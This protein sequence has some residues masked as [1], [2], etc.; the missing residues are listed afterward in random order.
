MAPRAVIYGCRGLALDAA[1]RAFFREAAPWGF[2]LFGRNVGSPDQVRRLVAELRA[3]VGREAPVLIDQEGGRV[4]RLGPPDWRGWSEAR[5]ECAAV[6]PALRPRAMALR[7][8]L[9]G[10]ELR[11]LGIDVN[12]APVLD[13]SQ[14]DTHPFLRSRLYGE[15]AG[16]VAA[17]GRAVADGLLAEGVLPI[18]KHIPGHGRARADSHE[19]LPVVEADLDALDRVDFAPFRDL[20]DLPMAMTAHVVYPALDAARPATLSPVVVKAIRER[21]GF[22]GLLMTDD[23]SMRALAGPMGE[24]VRL[25]LAAGCDVILHCNADPDEMAAIAAEAPALEGAAAER[26]ERALAM[27]GPGERADAAA[28]DAALAEL[29]RTAHA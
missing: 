24:R 26:A 18:V 17:I 19:A 2:I 14:P 27:R 23:L 16:E 1:E 20:A 10:Q 4:S 13:V 15:A 22:D 9:I 7:Y 12:C 6:P 25:S 5:E 3:T 8:R 11:A 28:L 21:I 29:R